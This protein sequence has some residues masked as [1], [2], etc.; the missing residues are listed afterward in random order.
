MPSP[1]E[2]FRVLLDGPTDRPRLGFGVYADAF[3]QII[4]HSEPQ[5]A[6]GI[7][8]DWGSG[9][10]T[11][12][13]AVEQRLRPKGELVLPVWF[14]AWRY[15]REE[16]LIV[17]MLDTLREAL[18]EWSSKQADE[19]TAARARKAAT[20]FGRAAR[21]ILRGLTITGGVPGIGATLELGRV[22]EDD[23]SNGRPGSFYHAAFRDMEEATR[24]FVA[25]DDS[26]TAESR[27]I[28]VF[29]DDLDRCL[30]VNAL[31]V[32][33]SMKLFFDLP[34]FVFVVGLDQGV[35]ERS[36]EAKYQA[37]TPE[38][39][40]LLI[41]R[42]TD[43]DDL[44][45]S[46]LRR[47]RRG[48]HRAPI[49][50][51]EYIKKIFQVPFTLPR[52]GTNQL[53]E[54]LDALR[55]TPEL[56]AS[57]ILDLDQTVRPHLVYITDRD[58]LN[59]R[60]VK[61]LINAYTLQ[62]KLLQPRLGPNLSTDTVLAIQLMGFRPDWLDLYE[63]LVGDPN[64]FVAEIQRALAQTPGDPPTVGDEAAPLPQS[65]LAYIRGRGAAMLNQP[66]LAPYVSSAEQ[67]RSVESGSQLAK[68]AIRTLRRTLKAWAEDNSL[69]DPSALLSE[70]GAL[71]QSLASLRT[72]ETSLIGD[73]T[74]QLDRLERE[75]KG[76]FSADDLD[77]SDRL[78]RAL[79]A[80]DRIDDVVREVRRQSF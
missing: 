68:P 13:R 17:P 48:D 26:P 65:F 46:A 24:S 5:F 62:V 43:E 1:Y 74:A 25:S 56:P 4:E 76:P 53:S 6:V 9:K 3:A 40:Q 80:L 77:R 19:A 33:E 31:Q 73:A 55:A 7:F 23:G 14:N 52:I 57:Q 72:S 58:T 30:P 70:A 78:R 15:E 66:T 54:L 51:A 32:L 37:G 45:T 41:E 27:R 36:I 67:T 61:R 28:V 69:V 71:R 64:D 21:A 79:D 75:I 10:T 39:P 35:I 42:S 34:G 11:L 16:H 22:L 47:A 12:M 49:S 2:E 60:E 44:G 29:I 18:V 63:V 20:M 50:G 38:T 8:G 59:P